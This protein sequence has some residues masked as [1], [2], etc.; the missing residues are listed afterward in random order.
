ME[1][2]VQFRKGTTPD[3]VHRDLD[4]LKDE[5]L[6]RYGFVGRQAQLYRENDPTQYTAEGLISMTDVLVEDLEPT[7]LNDADGAPL[8]LY[9]NADVR[10]LLSRR[11]Q[12]MPFFARNVG[13][14]ELWF[15]HR[16]HGEFQTEFG[17]IPYE[18]GDWVLLPKAVT[19][20][21]IPVTG[22]E[23]AF[24]IIEAVEEFRT[25]P[26]GALG[27]HFPFDSS[28]AFVPEP[29]VHTDGGPEWRIR[30][31]R[32]EE[33]GWLTYKHHPFDVRGWK[34]D[35]FPFKYN[36]RDYNPIGSESV[37]LPPTAQMFLQAEGVVVLNFLPRPAEAREGVERLPWFH[38][39]ADYD[40]VALFHSGDLFGVQM[41]PG[42]L[43]HA[44]QGIHHGPPEKAR[45]RARRK[46]AEY[47]RV[48]WS[49]MSI[50]T[51]KPLTVN[52]AVR[53]ISEAQR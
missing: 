50:D 23:Q 38:R 52:P 41:P 32:R 46:F 34:G 15:V 43:S 5:E 20:R 44:P 36:I 45:A 17:T 31:T 10:F 12:P 47:D 21:H 39:N 48:N 29:E 24:L 37:H 25:P 33:C 28:V 19:Y 30:L 51:R 40:E 35:Y 22:E 16:G 1:S 2:F 42:L 7:D 11:S 53:A 14:D 3:H 27:R 9:Y 49:V 6:G 26:P 4:G 13:G 8:M 18:P